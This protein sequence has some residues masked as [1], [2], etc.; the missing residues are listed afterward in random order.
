MVLWGSL[1]LLFPVSDWGFLFTHILRHTNSFFS[2]SPWCFLFALPQNKRSLSLFIFF[3]YIHLFHVYSSFFFWCLVQSGLLLFLKLAFLCYSSTALAGGYSCVTLTLTLTLL[4]FNIT[5]KFTNL[6]V[7]LSIFL[8]DLFVGTYRLS[9]HAR[10][11]AFIIQTKLKL[12]NDD[13]NK[14][15]PPKSSDKRFNAS[16]TFV[17]LLY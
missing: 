12:T 3:F 1:S 8:I 16:E 7:Q 6:L 4:F 2:R 13:V 10:L 11:E 17:W 14:A 5:Q 15:R 9:S